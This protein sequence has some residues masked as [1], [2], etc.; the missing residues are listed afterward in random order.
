MKN[1]KINDEIS[2]K[3]VDKA[4]HDSFDLVNKY[5]TYEIQPTADTT[6]FFPE[7]AQGFPNMRNTATKHCHFANNK[8]K[9]NKN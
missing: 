4:P 7:I 3:P 1:K 2:S 5:G 9:K 8:D 6:N